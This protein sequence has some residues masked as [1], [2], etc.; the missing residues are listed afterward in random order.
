MSKL[1]QLEVKKLIKELEYLRIDLDYKTE[2]V[3]EADGGFMREVSDFLEQQPELK[4]EYDKTMDARIQKAVQQST[5]QNVDQNTENIE[6][7][8]KTIDENPALKK[9]YREIVKITHPDKT[10]DSRLNDIYVRAGISYNGNEAIE[11]YSICDQLGIKYDVAEKEIEM[12]RIRISEIKDR[13]G[14]LESTNTWV[15]YHCEDQRIKDEIILRY[16][17]RQI[18]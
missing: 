17:A 16:V 12:M 13:I 15:W 1:T 7:E 2:I 5:E 9:I 6:G 3:Q 8:T 18:S 14:M 10:T 4:V 11:L